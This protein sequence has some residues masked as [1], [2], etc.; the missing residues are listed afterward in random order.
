[1][2]SRLARAYYLKVSLN[3]ILE[4]KMRRD[5]AER[6]KTEEQVH[7]QMVWVSSEL[8]AD[9]CSLATGRWDRSRIAIIDGED[10]ATATEAIEHDLFQLL[11]T[12]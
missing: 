12:Q 9:E 3:T 5:L 6:G 4:R 10:V 11:E 2:I 7:S 1:V 8:S